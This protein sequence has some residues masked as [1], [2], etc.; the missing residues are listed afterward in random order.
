M[1]DEIVVADDGVHVTDRRADFGDVVF[2]PLEAE[3]VFDA[4]FGGHD[5]QQRMI[6][7]L[8]NLAADERV[9]VPKLVSLDEVRVIAGEDEIRVVFQKQVGDIVQM[10]EPVER[11]RFDAVLFAQVRNRAARRI[12]SRRGRA[13]RILG[14][15]SVT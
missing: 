10:D 3:R 6:E 1:D 5:F 13:R 7:Q 4:A 11:G 15:A 9:Q 12:C 8:F 2:A 14:A